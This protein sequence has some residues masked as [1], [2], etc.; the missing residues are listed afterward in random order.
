MLCVENQQMQQ[1]GKY[2]DSR[3]SK[4]RHKKWEITINMAPNSI[5]EFINPI[6]SS[7]KLAFIACRFN[8]QGIVNKNM[9]DIVIGSNWINIFISYPP[10][11][12][13]IYY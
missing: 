8:A 5:P 3:Y 7:R 2:N 1:G 6:S 13:K 4:N 9:L 11:E 12:T 10:K